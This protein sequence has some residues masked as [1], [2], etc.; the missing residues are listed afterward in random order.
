LAQAT[1]QH[2]FNYTETTQAS[3]MV[4]LSVILSSVE[5]MQIT[6]RR[7]ESDVPLMV[8]IGQQRVHRLG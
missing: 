3:L 6:T 5:L 8:R 4:M 7:Q 1:Q 2:K